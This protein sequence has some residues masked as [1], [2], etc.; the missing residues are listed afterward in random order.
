MFKKK[1]GKKQT[2]NVLLTINDRICVGVCVSGPKLSFLA[3]WNPKKQGWNQSKDT[4]MLCI[5][6]FNI[7]NPSHTPFQTL[8]ITHALGFNAPFDW[9]TSGL[10]EILNPLCVSV[11]YSMNL[12]RLTGSRELF[13]LTQFQRLKRLQ[14]S[15]PS[16]CHFLCGNPSPLSQRP[17]FLSGQR[18]FLSTSF[19]C[20]PPCMPLP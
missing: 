17:L 16:L 10:N 12:F 18:C 1:R 3:V 20:F 6:F 8:P 15:W 13:P 7:S 2:N 5:P 11:F 9:C 14:T 4:G 19:S